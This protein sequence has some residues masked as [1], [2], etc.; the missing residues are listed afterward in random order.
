MINGN[1]SIL[2]KKKFKGKSKKTKHKRFIAEIKSTKTKYVPK[3]KRHT[4]SQ[5]LFPKEPQIGEQ[6]CIKP[7]I[8]HYNK[9]PIY[10]KYQNN[11]F[12]NLNKLNENKFER[13]KRKQFIY[14]SNLEF[15]NIDFRV[16]RKTSKM[17]LSIE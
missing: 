9:N 17:R 14:N 4:Y 2:N 5:I 1:P 7:M 6:K 12:V 13:N 11:S 3:S 16:K 15:N 8:R 10:F